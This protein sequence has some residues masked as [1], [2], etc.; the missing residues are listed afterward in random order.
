MGRGSV[1]AKLASTETDDPCKEMQGVQE[2]IQAAQRIAVVGGGAVGVELAADI[3]SFYPEKDVTIV[4]S[5][6]WLLSRFRPRLHEYVYRKLQDMDINVVLSERPR[7]TEG[8]NLP[9]AGQTPN[10]GILKYLALEAICPVTCHILVKPT[11]QIDTDR[12]PN[13][14]AMGDVAETGGP[15][16][17]SAGFF[18]TE[19]ILQNIYVMIR[20]QT[21][22][23]IYKPCL[24]IEGR[25]KLSLGKLLDLGIEEAWSV[26]Y[27]KFPGK[28]I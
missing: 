3:K 16:L 12:Y 17:A 1:P 9:C 15:R 19:T 23:N 5:R 6:E 26:V 14:F 27:L 10:S 2:S 24:V 20:G 25:L 8:K 21:S 28:V 7:I 4:H 18:Q 13:V 22:S 11:L